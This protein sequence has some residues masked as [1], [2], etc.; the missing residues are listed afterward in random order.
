MGAN[1]NNGEVAETNRKLLSI[2][3]PVLNEAGNVEL[4]CDAIRNTMQLLLA[5]YDYEV[6]FTDNHSTDGTF[7]KLTQMGNKDPRIKVVRFSRNFGYQ[8]S[9]LTGFARSKGDAAIQIDSDFQDPPDLIPEFVRL[10]ENGNQ[11]V[12][13]IRRSRK[14]S[15]WITGARRMF[16]RFVD[17]LSED[18]LPHDA[19]DF[20]LVDRRILEELK[21]MDDPQPYLRGT[22]A[23]IGFN[24]VG[25]PYDRGARA[26][27]ESKFGFGEML[28]L[29]LNGVFNHSI[30]P[31]RIA[32]FTGFG[33]A[34]LTFLLSVTYVVQKLFVGE[35]WPAGFTM[36]FDGA[37]API[38]PPQS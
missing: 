1:L 5:R 14:E 12:Y 22:I 8:L 20:R 16:Y 28:R 11:V 27:G 3:I 2:V 17:I 6:I 26:S 32:S 23:S 35:D 21:Q 38:T 33:V 36:F 9:I 24:Q 19:G 34:L 10:W 13:G 15:R 30:V 25:V 7:A 29:A 37:A 18:N 4:L 31:L